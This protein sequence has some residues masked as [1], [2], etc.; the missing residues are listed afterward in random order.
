MMSCLLPF[1]LGVATVLCLSLLSHATTPNLPT[2]SREANKLVVYNLDCR[3][4]SKDNQSMRPCGM[5]FA[6]P[7]NHWVFRF[8]I[9]DP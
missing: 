5:T 2:R 7:W 4:Y 3:A 1:V 9:R 6:S 8:E